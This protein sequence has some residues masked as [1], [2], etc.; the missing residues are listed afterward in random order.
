MRSQSNDGPFLGIL[1]RIGSLIGRL[2]DGPR[3]R[4]VFLENGVALINAQAADRREEENAEEGGHQEP[5]VA[6][7]SCAFRTRAFGII[8]KSPPEVR[9]SGRPVIPGSRFADALGGRRRRGVT[10]KKAASLGAKM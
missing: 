2:I 3:N 5:T 7:G 10:R 8:H 1:C 9:P 4:A 6:G